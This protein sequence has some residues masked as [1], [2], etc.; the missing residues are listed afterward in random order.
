MKFK[1]LHAC[2]V[3]TFMIAFTARAAAIPIHHDVHRIGSTGGPRDD[4]GDHGQF[5]AW[6]SHKLSEREVEEIEGRK[7]YDNVGA[8]LADG[9]EKVIDAVQNRIAKDKEMRG[10][11]TSGLV[12]RLYNKYRKFNF[13]VCHTD[14]KTEFRGRNGHI[15]HEVNVG[16]GKTVGFEIYWF[17]EGTF[18]RYGDGGYLN[19]AYY[20]NVLRTS[21]EGK[22]VVFGPR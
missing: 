14:H 15:H 18:H 7:F 4:S 17:K 1:T 19:W 10:R 21:N 9:L 2:F 6:S 12:A 13:V 11:Y 8:R 3:F 5:P 22:D 16:F 20:G